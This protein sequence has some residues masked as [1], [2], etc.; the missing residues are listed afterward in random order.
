MEK[1]KVFNP[2]SYNAVKELMKFYLEHDTKISKEA[3]KIVRSSIAEYVKWI[4]YEAEKLV[5]YGGNN[6]IN[7]DHVREAISLF[8]GEKEVK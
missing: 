2:I 4:T 6:T 1:E 8:L 5:R 3:V 7:A